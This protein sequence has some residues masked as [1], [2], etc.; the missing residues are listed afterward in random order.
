MFPIKKN[1][2]KN[3]KSEI[4]AIAMHLRCCSQE[5]IEPDLKHI[6]L[7]PKASLKY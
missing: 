2:I 7:G 5:F 1:I 3:R 4:D 6:I